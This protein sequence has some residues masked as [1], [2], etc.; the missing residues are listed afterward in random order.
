VSV[1][2]DKVRVS[3]TNAVQAD[4]DA[5]NVIAL[6]ERISS[7][8]SIASLYS[9]RLHELFEDPLARRTQLGLLRLAFE[10]GFKLSATYEAPLLQVVAERSLESD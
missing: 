2:A 1:L 10:G 9:D 7:S 8:P 5:R 6:V 3:V 4:D